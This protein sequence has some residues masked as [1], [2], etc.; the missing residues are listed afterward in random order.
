METMFHSSSNNSYLMPGVESY[1]TFVSPLTLSPFPALSRF[2]I[3]CR[4]DFLTAL[5]FSITIRVLSV[6]VAN[7]SLLLLRFP[8]FTSY[9]D[10]F[11]KKF[12]SFFHPSSSCISGFMLRLRIVGDF[13]DSISSMSDYS[14]SRLSIYS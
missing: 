5:S 9:Q 13:C 1:A 7:S 14:S 8:P 10:F 12:S 11:W 3:S 2:S 6:S 4:F